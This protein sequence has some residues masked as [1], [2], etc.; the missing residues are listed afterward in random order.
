MKF[1][2][3]KKEFFKKLAF[4]I[5]EEKGG[6]TIE[7]GLLIALALIMFIMLLNMSLGIINWIQTEI[8]QVLTQN[9][10]ISN[11]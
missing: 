6:S 5:F 3:L 1:S 11:P 7:S 8:T 4:L 10:F 2:D 9:D